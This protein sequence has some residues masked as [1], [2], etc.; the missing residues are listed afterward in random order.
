MRMSILENRTKLLDLYYKTLESNTGELPEYDG[1]VYRYEEDKDLFYVT[2]IKKQVSDKG[3]LLIPYGFDYLDESVTFLNKKSLKYLD[4]GTI[5]KIRFNTVKFPKSLLAVKG[6]YVTELGANTFTDLYALKTVDMDK[7]DTIGNSCFSGCKS[8]KNITVQ[9][10]TT[11]EDYAFLECEALTMLDFKSLEI[12]SASD[13]FSHSGIIHFTAKNLISL[14]NSF[15][16]NANNLEWVYT[17]NLS[18]L[19]KGLFRGCL[20]LKFCEFGILNNRLF[21]SYITGENYLD[22]HRISD[23]KDVYAVYTRN[24]NELFL[25]FPSIFSV[26]TFLKSENV[27]FVFKTHDFEVAELVVQFITLAY[28]ARN[29]SEGNLVNEAEVRNKFLSCYKNDRFVGLKNLRFEIKVL[30]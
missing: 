24:A 4:F 25:V 13:V 2:R 16:A 23:G 20:R 5:K 14:D 29:R 6:N 11:I 18:T 21:N 8:L 10:V 27:K 1:F 15:F 22:E 9:S 12:S 28:L 17:P 3:E 30:R 26:N 7:L 19:G